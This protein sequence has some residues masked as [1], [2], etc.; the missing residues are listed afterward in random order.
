MCHNRED[1]MTWEEADAEWAGCT[2]TENTPDDNDQLQQ[3]YEAGMAR[4]HEQ[5]E[6]RSRIDDVVHKATTISAP[7]AEPLPIML[8]YQTAWADS[9]GN[10]QFRADIYGLDGSSE[11]PSATSPIVPRPSTGP[12]RTS[13]NKG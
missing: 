8:T 12:I 13:S 3:A 10:V 11:V 1:E 9:E 4:A 7:L 6:Q 5:C 2:L